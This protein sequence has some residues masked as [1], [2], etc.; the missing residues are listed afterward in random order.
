MKLAFLLLLLLQSISSFSVDIR[1][2]KVPNLD[3]LL[4]ETIWALGKDYQGHL[5]IGSNSGLLIYDG[6]NVASITP[7]Q[8]NESIK[9]VRNLLTDKHGVTWIGTRENGLFHLKD[10]HLE[11]FSSKNKVDVPLIITAIKENDK[12]LWIGSDDS[13]FLITDQ[14]DLIPYPL[15]KLETSQKK[16]RI[17]TINELNH[18][19]FLISTRY[20]LFI[21]NFNSHTFVEKKVN[22]LK[23]NFINS[24]HKDSDGNIWLAS[25]FGVYTMPF[26]SD[27]FNPYLNDKI[28]YRI[29]TIAVDN[30]HLWLGSLTKGLLKVSKHDSSISSYQNETI[31][32][33]SI[34]GNNITSMYL[35]QSGVMFVSSFYGGLSYFDTSAL[36]FGLQSHS[37][38]LRECSESPI[39]HGLEVDKSGNLWIS[40]VTGLIE[41]D[42]LTNN[43]IKHDF[44]LKQ[45]NVFNTFHPL[46][47]FK[48]SN[49]TRWVATTKGFNKIDKSTGL[50]DNSNRQQLK[51]AI[52]FMFE[53]SLDKYMLGTS[54]GLHLFS[55]GVVEKIKSLE[56]NLLSADFY[57]YAKDINGR[58]FFATDSGLAELNDKNELIINSKVQSQLPSKRVYSIY[59]DEESNLWIGLDKN[60]LFR[61][62]SDGTLINR[63]ED[64]DGLAIDITIFSLLKSNDNLWIGTDS[65]LVRLDTETNKVHHFHESDGLQDMSFIL[66]SAA[67][68]DSGMLYFGGHNGLNAFYPKDI[69]LNT[70]PPN[71]VLTNLTRFGKKVQAGVEKDEF[72]I[73]KPINELDELLLSHK[74]YVI[75]FEFAALDFAD[76]SRN[77]YAFKMEGQDPD[78]NY[79]NA[80]DRKISYS[81]LAPGDYIFRVKAANKDGIWNETGKSLKVKVLPAPWLTWWAY[82][83]YILAFF[84]LL[85]AYMYRKNKANAEITK[86][87]RIEVDKQTKE[88]QVQKGKVENLLERKNELFANVSH[89]FRT[90]LTLILG[91][92]NKLLGSS[93]QSRDDVQSLQMVNR[94]A[95]RLL[96]MIEQLLQLAKMSHHE[97]VTFIPQQVQANL[98]TLVTSFQPLAET[99]K[100]TLTLI[101]NDD[102]AISATQDVIDVVFGNLISNAIKY[103]Q[104]G[105]EITVKSHKHDD[106]INIEV[107]DNGCGLDKKQQVEIFNRFTRLDSHLDIAG[108]GIGLSVVEEMLKVNNG[109]IKVKSQLGK[110]ST[111]AVRFHCVEFTADTKSIESNKTLVDQLVK[112]SNSEED[113]NSHIQYYG[114]KSHESILII[115]DN[116]DMRTHVADTLKHQY[117]CI[118]AD[119]G[120][121]GIA[122]AIKVVPDIIICDVMMPEMDG[123]QVSRVLRSDT[124][125]SHIPLILLTALNDKKSRIKGWRENIDVYLTKPFDA[126][127]LLIQLENILVIRNIL[128][129][130]AGA[131]LKS[132][133]ISMNSGLPKNDQMFVD[134]FVKLIAKMYTDPNFLRPQMANMMAVSDR[135]LQRKLKALIDKNPL[136]YL[137]EFRIKKAAEILKDGTQVSITADQCGF[138]SVTYFS[139]C[140]KDQYGVSPK[141]YQK[142][143]NNI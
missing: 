46:S 47:T 84:A 97:E 2:N 137:R 117:Y 129:K 54:D 17:R 3:L 14:N 115:D 121:T 22:G 118:T 130:K 62:N 18:E 73:N 50:I 36:S 133:K 13:L 76:P 41:I 119:R 5:L 82:T 7:K 44:D 131:A 10:N 91:P 90:P 20:S 48:D 128:K 26:G 111:F 114:S 106:F 35:D 88:L 37:L 52:Y 75:G 28:N 67:K 86:R 31:D 51:A 109:S 93:S 59:S 127:E 102:A 104:I 1:F 60:G 89:E 42:V 123:F 56:N 65:G 70:T 113:V 39:L 122:E 21:F 124:R 141:V 140:F 71:I 66:G 12:G 33:S 83:L 143:C 110:G 63:F 30:K 19:Q 108:V 38:N 96:T 69:K 34:S 134:K 11:K 120:K 8:S 100:I 99:K 126:Q 85:C 103:T 64:K 53:L 16:L 68:S 72:L 57:S 107:T 92:I 139:K 138:N 78:W 81:N 32:S 27:D 125:T 61:F 77:K 6:Y 79:V 136:D 23:N 80:D 9:N 25:D 135:Q 24:V 49:S 112:E 4:N 29:N 95:N 74:D 105:G 87:L 15:P 98:E 45:K 58:L 142:T 132:G 40:A 43:C 101:Q 94:N 55:K 116:L